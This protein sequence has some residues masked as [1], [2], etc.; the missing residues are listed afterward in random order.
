MTKH[1][2]KRI[3]RK[4]LYRLNDLSI[5]DLQ[6]QFIKTF[7]RI[8]L[9][10]DND[11]ES[12]IVHM[13]TFK[14]NYHNF[15]EYCLFFLDYKYLLFEKSL[16]Y[17]KNYIDTTTYTPENITEIAV[18]E[19]SI[20]E[21]DKCNETIYISN[22][23]KSEDTTDDYDNSD[24]Y[25]DEYI[26]NHYYINVNSDKHTDKVKYSYKTEQ[27]AYKLFK[28]KMDEFESFLETFHGNII[29]INKYLLESSL[30]ISN[31]SISQ[32]NS[33][34]E[35]LIQD[36]Y[37]FLLGIKIVG[38]TKNNV[39]NSYISFDKSNDTQNTN[40][41]KSQKQI[42]NRHNQFSDISIKSQQ[43]LYPDKTGA[44]KTLSFEPGYT[45][46][47]LQEDDTNMLSITPTFK[48]SRTS[49]TD[50]ASEIYFDKTL[51]MDTP[52]LEENLELVYI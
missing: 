31:D 30:T 36:F 33:L 7:Q 2:L 9:I 1:K 37:L 45:L 28:N 43:Y 22:L 17:N 13:D 29:D 23:A 50:Q 26:D 18:L 8:P 21:Y 40:T 48:V 3:N 44:F 39:E 5:S 34:K 51:V 47:P 41:H 38:N 46:A 24:E 4:D 19:D 52:I 20:N 27:Y 12:Y 11:I 14:I 16:D 25:S 35:N 49:S 42:L 10:Q 15:K 6:R 32:I